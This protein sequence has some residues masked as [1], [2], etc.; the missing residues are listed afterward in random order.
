LGIGV[1]A[2]FAAEYLDHSIKNPSQLED[3]VAGPLL[4]T[5][6]EIFEGRV[7]GRS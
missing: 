1:A 4:A 2:A 6:P 7:S 3:L 5:I